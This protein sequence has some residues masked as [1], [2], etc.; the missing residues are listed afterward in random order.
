MHRRVWRFPPQSANAPPSARGSLP[1]SK[2]PSGRTRIEMRVPDGLVD[3]LQADRPGSP[4]PRSSRA[5]CRPGRALST[6]LVALVRARPTPSSGEPPRR[7]R[8]SSPGRAAR[9]RFCALICGCAAPAHRARPRRPAG[10][11]GGRARAS[12]VWNGRFPGP[13]SFGWPDSRV[14]HPPRSCATIP[15]SGSRMPE[16]KLSHRLWIKRDG[17][18]FGVGRDHGDRVAASRGGAPARPRWTRRRGSGRPEPAR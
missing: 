12:S 9:I 11:H 7:R 10:P 3:V 16:P 15:V 4:R 2:P 8:R 13:I 6:W 5:R 1:T 17:P 18:P 14:K